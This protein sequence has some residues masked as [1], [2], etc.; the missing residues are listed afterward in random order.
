MARDDID[1]RIGAHSFARLLGDWRPPGGRGLTAAL[2]DR[3]R[4]LVLDGRLPLQTR[5]PAEREL[6]TVLDVSRT[7]IAA[8]YETL[9]EAGILNSRRGAGSWTQ[10][11]PGTVDSRDELAVLSARRPRPV[12]PRSRP[13]RTGGGAARGGGAGRRRPRR[14]PGRARLQ[15]AR[16]PGAAR[17]CRTTVHRA[18]PADHGGPGADHLRRPVRDRA[19]ARGPRHSRRPGA[20]RAPDLPER[21]RG[22][23]R[24]RRPVRPGPARPRLSRRGRVGPGAGDRGGAR[25]RPA[26]GLPDPGPPEPDRGAARR[27][28]AR[29]A[30]RAGPA[31]RDTA[32][33]RRDARRADARRARG[34][35]RSPCTVPPTRPS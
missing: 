4:L 6:A 7:T 26:P 33:D 27:R 10:V 2:A 16:P 28:G 13:P 23:A 9:R 19:R 34:R 29:A 31:H 5:V 8:A 25:R 21:A 12:R 24:A 15:P 35:H 1:R 20:R 3:V 17:G 11:P 14:A 32:A 18:R 30:R 22:R